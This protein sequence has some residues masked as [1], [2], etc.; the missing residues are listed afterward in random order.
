[1]VKAQFLG[2]YSLRATKNVSGKRYCFVWRDSLAKT[3]LFQTLTPDLKPTGKPM[4]LPLEQF[5]RDFVPEPNITAVPDI[6]P[7]V[8]DY[9]GTAFSV[10]LS[11]KTTLVSGPAQKNAPFAPSSPKPVSSPSSRPRGGASSPGTQSAAPQR[12]K[13]DP[14]EL[15]KAIRAEFA[16]SLMRFRRGN[17]EGA[18]E[19]FERLLAVEEGIVPAHKH[20]FTDFGIDLRKSKLYTLASRFFQRAV[21]LSPNDGHALFNLARIYYE[22]GN[23]DKTAQYLDSALT[24]EPGLKCAQRLKTYMRDRVP[25]A[26]RG[27][28]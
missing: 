22:M 16:L 28:K 19:D 3:C 14:E 10:P 6:E 8:A 25:G 9:L 18:L 21:T 11:D 2:V 7:Q 17:K 13:Q 26:P 1:M 27:K 15:D 20:M 24:K 12:E 5:R 4:L 23:Y